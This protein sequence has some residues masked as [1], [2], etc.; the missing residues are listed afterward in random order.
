MRNQDDVN[1]FKY[2]F[3]PTKDGKFSMTHRL[4]PVSVTG[5]KAS[6]FRAKKEAIITVNGHEYL[7]DSESISYMSSILAI[8]NGK[9]NMGLAAG[10]D[11][12][13]LNTKIYGMTIPWN[14]RFGKTTNVAIN[15]LPNAIETAM[16]KIATIVAAQ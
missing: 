12:A 4:D 10:M 11:A 16:H 3:N 9:F 1:K 14:D 15:E 5:K 8:A 6:K 13:D 2:D 7:A